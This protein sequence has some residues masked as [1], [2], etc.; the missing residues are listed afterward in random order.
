MNES[1]QYDQKALAEIVVLFNEAEEAIK[2]I[3]DFGENL[4]V[5]AVNQLRYTGNHLVRYLSSSQNIEELKDAAKHVKRATYDAYEAAILYHI[6]EYNKFKN[7]Y[8]GVVVSQ[9]ISDYSDIQD[10]I[11]KARSFVRTNGESKTRGENYRDGRQHLE[12]IIKETRRLNSSRDELNKLIKKERRDF[13]RDVVVA[14]GVVAGIVGAI[15]A[16]LQLLKC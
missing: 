16:C 4:I 8:R 2:Y 12:N 13:L 15:V 5:P 7:D 3:E 14:F 9:V 6:L 1:Q 11:E 10:S